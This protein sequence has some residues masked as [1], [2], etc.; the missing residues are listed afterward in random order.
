MCRKL[1]SGKQNSVF[2]KQ[3]IDL[4]ESDCVCA[5]GAGVSRETS[6]RLCNAGKACKE[7]KVCTVDEPHEAGKP[8]MADEP[9]KAGK[10]CS[11]DETCETGK[12]CSTDETCE[13]GKPCSDER[14]HE[15]EVPS[16]QRA[17]QTQ[18]HSAFGLSFYDNADMDV[19]AQKSYKSDM[20]DEELTRSRK[21]DWAYI[22]I[23]VPLLIGVI[24]LIAL[25][26]KTIE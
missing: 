25:I 26:A 8:C 10:P 19:I 2:N 1:V 17:K 15:S 6:D 9:H 20:S 5:G 22:F 24:Y 14:T 21:R 4:R 3:D 13:A 18:R 11:A 12:P 23:G 7:G 16:K